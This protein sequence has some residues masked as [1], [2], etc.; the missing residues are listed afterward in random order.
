M[1]TT[2]APLEDDG[3]TSV[4][5]KKSTRAPKNRK[6]KNRVRERTLEEKLQAREDALR[7]SGYLVKC[8]GELHVNLST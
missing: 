4:T 5:Y 7:R 2:A 8:R 6:G 1:T 3:F